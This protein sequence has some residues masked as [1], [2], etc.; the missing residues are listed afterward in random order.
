MISDN[1]F[2]DGLTNELVKEIW[3]ASRR[4]SLGRGTR[5]IESS[6]RA[7]HIYFLTKGF[8]SC[9]IST[10][11]GSS[12]ETGMVG[13][14]GIVGSHG[15]LGKAAGLSDCVLQT[16]ATAWR[17]DMGFACSLFHNSGEFRTRV[18]SVIQMENSVM[19]QLSACNALHEAQS[20]L[21]RWLLMASD[22]L[23]ETVITATQQTMADMLG[24]RRTTLNLAANVLHERGIIRY[25]RGQVSI[26]DL[27]GL[28]HA[29]CS[30][31]DQIRRLQL[32]AQPVSDSN[33]DA[34]HK[35]PS[36]AEYAPL[37]GF[38]SLAFN[39]HSG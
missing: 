31:Y 13:P 35:A 2:L 14:E 29:A 39:S 38:Y 6:T 26:C 23:S 30:C 34:L 7:D 24:V 32:S 20:R 17:L 10:P 18:L 33:I 11:E 5:L 9:F 27:P 22:R 28:R 19:A 16:P 21:A 1:C 4:V 15:L 3:G 37:A 12:T 36:Q 8:A 25:T